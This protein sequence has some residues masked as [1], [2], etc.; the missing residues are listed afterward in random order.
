MLE[1]QVLG[2]S[3]AEEHQ[4]PLVLLRHDTRVLPILV[5][6]AEAN[7]I[8]MGL[9]REKTA[10]PM[11]HDLV[12]NLL[13]G[14]RGTLQSVTIYRLENDTFFAHLNVE[15]KNAQGHVE[16]IL[17][18]DTRPSDGIAIAVRTG[19]PIYAAEE[20]LDM[21][22]QDASILGESDDDEDDDADNDDEDGEGEGDDEYR[23]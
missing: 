17:R 14:L 16:Q 11:T 5:G 19:C 7:A 9:M 2:V 18:I 1:L 21:A 13:A 8:H 12:C 22:G 6:T 4:Y 23:A 15:Q 10:R 3:Q 20:V